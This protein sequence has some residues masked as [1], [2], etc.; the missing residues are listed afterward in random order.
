MGKLFCIYATMQK[1]LH[2]IVR[3]LFHFGEKEAKA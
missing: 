3:L 1:N 2:V